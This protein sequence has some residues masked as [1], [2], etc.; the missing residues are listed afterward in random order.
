MVL[1]VQVVGIVFAVMLMYFTFLNYKR[2]DMN[3]GE[4]IF[5]FALWIVFIYV[6]LVPYSLSFIADTLQLVRLMDLFTIS[7]LMFLIVL[8]FYNYM[9]TMHTKRKIEHVVRAIALRKK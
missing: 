4:F 6:T 5:W 3:L 2:K 9:M 7:A 8:T 1:V